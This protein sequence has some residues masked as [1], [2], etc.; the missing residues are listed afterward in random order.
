MIYV[1]DLSGYIFCPRKVYLSRVLGV[2]AEPTSEQELGVLGH[3]VRR[4]L[5]VRQARLMSKMESAEDIEP[6]LRSG[7]DEVVS[8]LPYILADGWRSEYQ[9]HLPRVVAEVEGELASLGEEL[10][11]LV[12]E[13]G[14][15][16]ALKYV[17]PWR[18]EYP[19]RSERLGLSG[20]IDKVMRQKS[21][22]PVDIKTGKS[23]DAVFG[24][25]RV[26]VCA[27]GML[28]EEVLGERVEYGVLEYTRNSET[29]TVRFTEKLKRH[30]V[31]VRDCV[32][33]LL[34]GRLPDVCPHGQPRKC[35]SCSM[36]D[37][38]YVT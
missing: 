20:R 11:E 4:E 8:D 30:V 21:L 31:E 10:C 6:L 5:S 24:G 14:F 22:V 26:Q 25:D 15:S 35:G 16:D 17:T 9:K 28:L 18:I 13:L 3:A 29:S 34:A 12:D 19:V 1:S 38:C 23:H 36:R 37:V 32:R 27:Y 7:L 33:S 2:E